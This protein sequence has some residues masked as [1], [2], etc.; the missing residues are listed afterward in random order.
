MQVLIDIFAARTG[1]TPYFG[2]WKKLLFRELLWETPRPGRIEKCHA[3]SFFWV[4]F[5]DSVKRMHG[6]LV[7]R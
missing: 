6:N 7:Q 3:P 2:M 4:C 5:D 1:L